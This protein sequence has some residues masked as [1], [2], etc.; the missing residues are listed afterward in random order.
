M[1]LNLTETEE[2]SASEIF[3]QNFPPLPSCELLDPNDDQ[4]LPKLIEVLEKRHKL[5]Q[6]LSEE[7]A[8]NGKNFNIDVGLDFFD[9]LVTTTASIL[10]SGLI[11]LKENFKVTELDGSVKLVGEQLLL[12]LWG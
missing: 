3:L 12:M 6:M 8:K 7:F 9:A 11:A 5:R 1:A 4:T 10:L 2:Q